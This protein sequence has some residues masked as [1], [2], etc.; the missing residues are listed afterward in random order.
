M[1]N[2]GTLTVVESLISGNVAGDVGGGLH[3]DGVATVV[4]SAVD[5]NA[6]GSAGAGINNLERLVL[7]ESTVSGNSTAIGRG[8]GI[9]NSA[10]AELVSTTLS[11]NTAGFGGGAVAN[12][13]GATLTNVTISDNAATRQAGAILNDEGSTVTLTN[14]IVA[15]STG[16]NCGGAGSF[17]SDGHNLEDADTC[18]LTAEGDLT[19]T[20]PLLGALADN[21]GPTQTHALLAGSP[22]VDAGD[23]SR[24][25]PTDQR[26]ASR[27]ADGNGD[28]TAVCD[29]GAHELGATVL[30]TP[31]RTP[32][33]SRPPPATRS[34][35]PRPSATPTPAGRVGDADC[36]GRVNSVDAALVLQ[37]NAGLLRTLPCE[38]LA[39][40]NG[41]GRIDAVD[42]ALILQH[43]AGLLDRL[44]P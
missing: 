31:T 7:A 41:D 34:P 20:E 18:G 1:L 27:P 29:I 33:L 23:D 22:A 2:T 3:N 11:G 32:T 38:R 4:R 8:G 24:C 42:A 13:G 36:N 39:D 15:N 9:S 16:G 26:G 25:P 30:P 19:D 35:T 40:A 6:A 14:S 17:A 28:G 12:F 10:D 5:G 21:G 43:V 44:P 37:R